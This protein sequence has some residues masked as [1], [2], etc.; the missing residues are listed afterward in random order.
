M[1]NIR[2]KVQKEAVDA[3]LNSDGKGI[4]RVS[5]RVGKCRISCK[6][7]EELDVTRVLIVYPQV[8][9]QQSWEDEF[10][11]LGYRP[12][13]VTY[14][15]Y[16]SLE[17]LLGEQYDIIIYDEC[18]DTSERQREVMETFL[19]ETECVIGLTG[20]LNYQDKA[21]LKDIGLDVIYEYDMQDGIEDGIL[22]PYHIHVIHCPLDN[23]ERCYTTSKGRKITE[24]QKYDNFSFVISRLKEEGKDPFHMY[25][26]RARIL[27]DA[28]SR[29]RRCKKLITQ[30]EGKRTLFF[31]GSQKFVEA[32]GIPTF[33][34]KTKD[35][36]PYHDFM[37]GRIDKLGVVAMMKSGVTIPKLQVVVIAKIESNSSKLEQ[38]IGR[39]LLMDYENKKAQIIIVGSG[40]PQEEKR[41][42]KALSNLDKRCIT[43]G[44]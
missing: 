4:L 2:D 6:I 12:T 25:L 33:H 24:K 21:E 37:E 3:Y 30:L 7:M 20:T 15:T 34:S 22:P 14:T 31:G 8:K 23:K 13:D 28:P 11:K 44:I 36:T 29:L 17:K 5:V 1:S 38:Q 9:I 41:L 40:E 32:L 19:Q 43:Y 16:V 39:C 18:D 26:S 10:E 35:K 42:K 27:V